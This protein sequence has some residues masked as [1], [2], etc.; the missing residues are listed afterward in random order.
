MELIL[1]VLYFTPVA[2]ALARH[3][4]NILAVAIT[5]LILGWTVIGWML[6]LGMAILG[7]RW[8]PAQR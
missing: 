6:G 7:P 1:I 2:I 8:I 3:N 4:R 5:S